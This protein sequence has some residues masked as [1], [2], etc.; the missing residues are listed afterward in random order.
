[1]EVV[2]PM[3]SESLS[4]SAEKNLLS[5]ITMVSVEKFALRNFVVNVIVVQAAP[6]LLMY[7]VTKFVLVIQ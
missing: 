3:K 1:V 7:R 5:L 2:P 6:S 4:V